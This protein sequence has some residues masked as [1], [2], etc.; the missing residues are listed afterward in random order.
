MIGQIIYDDENY[1]QVAEWCNNNN[2]RLI[3][4]E[5]DEKGRRFQVVE[6]VVDDKFEKRLELNEVLTKLQETDY[7]TNKIVEADTEEERA[8][9]RQEYA[10]MLAQRKQW[11]LRASDLKDLLG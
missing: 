2:C 11:R 6:N 10:E 9:I 7:I 4:I 3:E 8:E 5:P 1:S